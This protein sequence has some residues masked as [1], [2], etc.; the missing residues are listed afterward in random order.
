MSGVRKFRPGF[1]WEGVDRLDYK[2]AGSHFR[3]ISRRVLFDGPHGLS[4]QL[5]YFEIEPG[6]HSTLERHEHVH[7]VI[8]LRGR[9]RVL[10][11]PSIHDLAPFDLVDIT[12]MTWHQFRA[13][14][15]DPLGFLC[16]VDCE[17]DRPQR[18]DESVI[19][20]L[21]ATP[22]IAAFIRV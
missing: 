1:D 2:P 16:L 3:D 10:L 20:E 21:R 6:G 17:R 19:E 8:V 5:R 18:P 4:S 22:E 12:P 14:D 13:S 7:A 11:G 9:G 15:D